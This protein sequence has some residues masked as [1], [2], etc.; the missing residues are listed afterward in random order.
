MDAVGR[1]VVVTGGNDGLGREIVLAL[2]RRGWDVAFTCTA[3]VVRRPRFAK[4]TRCSI[5]AT[6]RSKSS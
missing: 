1:T 5:A 3:S 2:A 4:R 6:R